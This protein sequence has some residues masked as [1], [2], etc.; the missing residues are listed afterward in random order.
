MITLTK[1]NLHPKGLHQGYNKLQLHFL[2]L[3]WPPERGWLKKLIGTE[4]MELDYERFIRAGEIGARAMR[5]EI[6]QTMNAIPFQK[7]RKP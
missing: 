5:E 2:G 3:N 6:R 7:L 4:I 1:E